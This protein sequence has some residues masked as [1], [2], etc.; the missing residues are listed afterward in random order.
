MA[1]EKLRISIRVQGMKKQSKSI[2]YMEMKTRLVKLIVFT[3]LFIL[4]CWLNPSQAL[5]MQNRQ[6][7]RSNNQVILFV[8]LGMP[9]A[10]L[11]SFLKQAAHFKIPVVIRGLYS[12][13]LRELSQAGRDL[14]HDK[15]SALGSFQETAARVFNL[16]QDDVASRDSI[17]EKNGLEERV[18]Q[19]EKGGVS[20]DP[21]LFRRFSI[22]V[23]PALV[24]VSGSAACML[25]SSS[26][27]VTPCEI[28]DYDV[29]YGNLPLQSAMQLLRDKTESSSRQLTLRRLIDLH[30]PQNSSFVSLRSTT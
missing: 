15:Q 9:E 22:N 29:V 8:S 1:K 6:A 12:K 23:V 30:V 25:P 18:S 17:H 5:E 13:Q 3:S 26:E 4:F 10:V 7:S 20:I 2:R 27:Q 14:T 21:T 28:D 24:V 19:K 11:K 16:L